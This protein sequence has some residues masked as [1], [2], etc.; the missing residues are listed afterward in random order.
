M[1]YRTLVI[2]GFPGTGKTWLAQ[3]LNEQGV[4]VFDLDAKNYRTIKGVKNPDFPT[5]YITKLKESMGK[6]ETIFISAD[7]DII[8]VLTSQ[9]FVFS[10][11]YSEDSLLSEYVDHQMYRYG[12]DHVSLARAK[13]KWENFVLS[14]N[15]HEF[16]TP[17]AIANDVHLG[18]IYD[19][20]CKDF[21]ARVVQDM[22]VKG[23]VLKTWLM[24]ELH[25]T[26]KLSSGSELIALSDIE[27]DKLYRID[28]IERYNISIEEVVVLTDEH[29]LSQWL[30]DN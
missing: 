23:F 13:R 25:K 17:Y 10:L 5:N 15:H 16:A 1:S 24:K 3:D 12:S 20:I 6:Y 26:K 7:K 9:D 29:S 14:L 4:R 2:A 11:V 18:D 22:I 30:K 28:S 19:N 27:D 21:G 8:D